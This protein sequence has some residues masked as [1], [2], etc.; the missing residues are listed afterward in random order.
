MST[1]LTQGLGKLGELV[2]VFTGVTAAWDAEAEVKVEALEQVIAKVV[3]LDHAE[4]A[5]GPVAD[6][7][8]HPDRMENRKAETSQL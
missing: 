7:E 3:P 6:C 5:E 8:F 1:G 2:D 4:V